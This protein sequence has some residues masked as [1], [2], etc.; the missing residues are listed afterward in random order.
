MEL[1]RRPDCRRLVCDFCRRVVYLCSWCDRGQRYCCRDCGDQ[2]RRRSHREA[3]SRYQRTRRGRRCHARRQASY[4]RR[5]QA[6]QEIV[7]HQGCPAE[8]GSGRVRAWTLIRPTR[9]NRHP[10]RRFSRSFPPP[11]APAATELLC[12]VCGV[13]CE[14]FVREDFLR[15]RRGRGP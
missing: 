7:T 12:F 6:A 1:R 8:S 11:P 14:P 10:Y 13:P 9:A 15:C 5:Q 4:R 3:G 2:A